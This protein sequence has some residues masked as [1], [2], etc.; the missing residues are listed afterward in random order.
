[1]LVEVGLAA[2]AHPAIGRHRAREQVRA[3]LVP[4][5]LRLRRWGMLAVAVSV[6]V[7]DVIPDERTVFY[8]QDYLNL[9]HSDSHPTTHIPSR[10]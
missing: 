4:E 1:V 3:V 7:V 8:C 10:R 2:E 9:N 5:V 6:G